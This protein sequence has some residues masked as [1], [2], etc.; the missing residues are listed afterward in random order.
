MSRNEFIYTIQT[1]S[2]FITQIHSPMSGYQQ[3]KNFVNADHRLNLRYKRKICR[4]EA[5][6]HI[7]LELGTRSIRSISYCLFNE[8]GS[9]M[10]KS[11]NENF[12][13]TSQLA[14]LLQIHPST[15]RRWRADNCSPFP[16]IIIGKTIRYSLV[17]IT[18]ILNS[19]KEWGK[20]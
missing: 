15:L 18:N 4:A 6:C 2:S 19:G 17:D 10:V 5:T 20:K 9:P 14:K 8:R 13:T 11:I 1:L 16:F 7:R 3:T 12:L